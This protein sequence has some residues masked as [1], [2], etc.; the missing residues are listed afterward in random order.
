MTIYAICYIIKYIE[1][2]LDWGIGLAIFNLL[3]V[4]WAKGGGPMENGNKINLLHM[5][6]YFE[7]KMDVVKIIS[8]LE[9]TENEFRSLGA[10]LKAMAFFSGSENDIEEF[11]LSVVVY[12]IYSLIYAESADDFDAAMWMVVNK[13]QYMERMRL[14]MYKDVFDIYGLQ[15]FDITTPD[16][17]NYC[18][19]LTAIHAGI[20][21]REKEQF[22]DLLEQHLDC[23]DRDD[24]YSEIY[25]DL[26]IR[27]RF[28][29]GLM[30]A[31]SRKQIFIKCR[32]MMKDVLSGEYTEEQLFERYA[33]MSKSTIRGCLAWNVSKKN[34]CAVAYM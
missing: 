3:T 17:K 22:F 32:N 16:L 4:V 6:Q 33:K 7:K 5:Q 10:K 14:Q 23:E 26:P 13:S 28:I 19:Q 9:L 24:L 15:T 30:D 29:F 1:S 34:S 27:T 31:A 18:R 2:R 11:M 21:N 8:D 20:P 12:N 25:I